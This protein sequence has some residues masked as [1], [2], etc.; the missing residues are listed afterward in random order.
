MMRFRVALTLLAMG[1]ALLAHP[2]Y[3]HGF[4]ERTELPVPLGFI[5]I[6]AGA[7]VALSFAI[8]GVFVGKKSGHGGYWQY[9]LFQHR[10]VRNV[11]TRAVLLLP[12]RLL[13]AF[14]LGL[15]VATGLAGE[16]IPSSNFAPTFVWIIWWVGLAFFVAAQSMGL[17]VFLGREP[18]KQDRTRKTTLSGLEVPHGMGHMARHYPVYGVRLDTG[19][20]SPIR[21]A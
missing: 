7:A 14:L 21:P 16:Q 20:V 18:I 10:W 12:L 19:C 11:L 2:A 1:A 13:S 4:G 3:A 9:N 6:G 5:L 17:L 15:V 8:I